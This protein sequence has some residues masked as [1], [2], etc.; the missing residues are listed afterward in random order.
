M[1]SCGTLF[2]VNKFILGDEDARE[3]G[4]GHVAIKGALA[5]RD[6]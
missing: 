3:D 4:E 2:G 5:E 1:L 6:K